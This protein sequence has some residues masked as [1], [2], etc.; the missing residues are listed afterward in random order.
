MRV[1]AIVGQSNA[2][3]QADL[4]GG[5]SPQTTIGTAF[6]FKNGGIYPANDPI[7]DGSHGSAWPQFATSYANLT[8]ETVG[9]IQTAVS[10]SSLLAAADSGQ[11]NWSP[12]GTL[13]Q[14]SILTINAGLTA[15]AAVGHHVKFSGILFLQGE[16][17]GGAIN[18]GIS[19]VTGPNYQAALIA[20]IARYRAEYYSTLPFYIFRIGTA[21]GVSDNGL[22]VIRA[23]Q[24][25]VS[26]ADS[27]SPIVFRGTVDFPS[28]GLMTDAVHY[29][30]VGY[31]EMGHYGAL[32]IIA[33]MESPIKPSLLGCKL[34]GTNKIL[35]IEETG[36]FNSGIR[37]FQGGIA[38][39]F[40][41]ICGY[42]GGVFS[43]TSAGDVAFR[44]EGRSLLF[45]QNI[46][47]GIPQLAITDSG[48]LGLQ[49]NAPRYGVHIN[50]EVGFT[51]TSAATPTAN[52]DLTLELSSNTSLTLRAKG[53]DGATRS[54]VLQLS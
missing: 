1:F 4:S 35:D 42:A 51:P 44:M 32:S 19:G 21:V 29:S 23:A 47:G 25:N 10:G 33:G 49:T 52:G 27:N 45:G 22:S 39:A 9:L 54:V 7:A 24:E 34:S 13:Y 3:G 38:R 2:V 30:Q 20:L 6:Q 36:V 43:G 8:G 53:S 15:F 5:L 17:E 14:A 46:S 41:G 26:A 16:A 11:G 28:R 37:W 12:T 48:R 50:G 40:L 18:S 31:N